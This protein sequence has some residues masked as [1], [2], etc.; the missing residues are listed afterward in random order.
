MTCGK[1]GGR[2]VQLYTGARLLPSSDTRKPGG[3]GVKLKL[4]L[5]IEK[6]NN[7]KPRKT[8][9][10]FTLLIR[11]GFKCTFV[12]RTLPFLHGGLLERVESILIFDITTECLLKCLFL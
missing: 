11:K 3:R 1:P 10:S 4:Q 9:V 2:G 6:L 8:T 12:N 5:K 7:Y